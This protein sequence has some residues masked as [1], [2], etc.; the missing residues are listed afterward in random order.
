VVTAGATTTSFSGASEAVLAN[1]RLANISTRAR[2]GTGDSVTIAGFVI[3]G[4][5][6]KPVLIRAIGPTLAGLGISTALTAPKLELFRSGS[7]TPIATNIGWATSSNTASIIAATVSAGAFALGNN[8]AD[9]VIFTTLAPGAYTAVIS[10]A[11]NTPGVALAEVYDLSA[12]AAGQKLFNISTRA[13]TGAGDSTLI[14]GIVVSGTVPKRVLIRGV[15]PTLTTHGVVGALT[16]PQLTVVKD[17][18]TV[19]ANSNW[20]TSP[21]AAA[22]AAASAQV[23]AFALGT[24]STDAAMIVSLAPGNYSASVVGANG[25]AGIAIIEIYEL[26]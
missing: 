2:V 3:S 20:T 7:S 22:I 1:Q 10:S 4:Q 23:G 15:G 9:S 19:A 13:S 26:P 6:S 24:S 18:V 11:N 8:A 17:G 25:T 21:D 5:E 16:Q 14:A 12:P